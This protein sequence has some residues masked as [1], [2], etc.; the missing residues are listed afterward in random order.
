MFQDILP[1][2]PIHLV[3]F[4]ARLFHFFIE[5]I[6]HVGLLAEFLV[7]VTV[8]HFHSSHLLAKISYFLI[9]LP[10]TIWVLLLDK[11]LLF[12]RNF[13]NFF[14]WGIVGRVV[15]I[16]FNIISHTI[17]DPVPEW[18]NPFCFFMGDINFF[19]ELFG[20]SVHSLELL[21]LFMEFDASIVGEFF[22]L[23]G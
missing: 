1:H 7:D 11:L 10:L 3:H 5:F 19:V 17:F 18:R 23:V 22:W 12:R 15:L 9:V 2:F 6:N 4:V 20:I 21:V 14:R 16:G 13:L 8:H